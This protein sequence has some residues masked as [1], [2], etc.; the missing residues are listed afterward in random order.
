MSILSKLWIELIISKK[1]KIEKVSLFL[2]L[3]LNELFLHAMKLVNNILEWNMS[4]TT[5]M[6]VD[7]FHSMQ[8]Y[9]HNSKEMPI[10]FFILKKKKKTCLFFKTGSIYGLYL[11]TSSS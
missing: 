8:N 6:I 2:L 11:F 5:E 1:S 10:L 7:E 3:L 9:E 4:F